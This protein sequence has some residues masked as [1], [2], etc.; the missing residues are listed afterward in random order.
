MSRSR[1]INTVVDVA[2]ALLF[3]G[4]AVLVLS[5]V[6]LSPEPKQKRFDADRTAVVL[7]TATFD[8]SY[9]IEPVLSEA[10]ATSEELDNDGREQLQEQRIAHETMAAHVGDAALG[11]LAIDSEQITS[12]GRY[13]RAAIDNQ[14]TT[15]L[16]G[17]QFE[18]SVTALWEPYP[19]ASISGQATV[20]VE[21][22]PN[23]DLRTR[24]ITVPSG[25]EPTRERAIAAVDRGGRYAAVAEIV[26]DTTIDGYL[27]V[28]GSKHALERDGSVRILTQYRYER[29]A[30]L[31]DEADV[32][33]IRDEIE[34][35]DAE[36]AEA[37]EELSAALAAKLAPEL[38]QQFD[39]P[40]AAARAVSTDSIS[41]TVRTWEP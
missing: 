10:V 8:V 15:Q 24:T 2:F 18:T 11:K 29:L 7:G 12:T 22:P 23:R 14:L 21:P 25:F 33:E 16:A 6:N 5:A 4:I 1:A 28:V 19:N 39:S 9:T 38:R 32:E 13:Y 36:P 20:G 3:V 30:K 37:N 41:I 27:P 17:S 26:A 34:Q 40:E 31:L 35:T